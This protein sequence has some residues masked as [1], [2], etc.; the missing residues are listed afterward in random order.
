MY[1]RNLRPTVGDPTIF[2]SQHLVS[3]KNDKIDIHLLL[4][5]IHLVKRTNHYLNRLA[6]KKN[7]AQIHIIVNI[8]F[9]TRLISFSYLH[10]GKKNCYTKVN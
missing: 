8:S 7:C 1:E 10:N 9:M 2:E 3:S 6:G 5:L 4:I